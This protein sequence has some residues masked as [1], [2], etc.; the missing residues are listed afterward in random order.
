MKPIRITTL[1]LAL[2]ACSVVSAQNATDL[3]IN[4]V[5][6]NNDSNIVDDY[7]RH[8]GWLEIYNTSYNTVNIGGL[9]LTDDPQNPTKSMIAK[10]HPQAS[11]PSRSHFI[12]YATGDGSTGLRHL[13]FKLECGKTIYLFDGNGR[14]LLDSVTLPAAMD[15]DISYGRETDGADRWILTQTAT[16]AISNNQISA[17]AEIDE[18]KKLDPFGAGMAAIAMTIVLSSLAT[19]YVC[20][21]LVGKIATRKKKHPFTAKNA[22]TGEAATDE[23]NAAIALALF[24][25]SKQEHDEE[26]TVLTMH[27]VSRNYSPWSS[28]I[29]GMRKRPGGYTSY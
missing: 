11:I 29:Y 1:L 15:A 22:Q 16:P 14:T 26:Y 25:H 10:N 28:K 2:S 12:M 27:K 4:E 19:L 3:R 6:V 23:V 7:G 9:F 24:L 5:M 21:K 13:T 17:A 18:F 8:T 20:F